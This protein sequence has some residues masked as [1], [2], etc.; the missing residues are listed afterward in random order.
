VELRRGIER[1]IQKVK[2]G[3]YNKTSTSSA[4]LRQEDESGNKYIRVCNRR[5]V[6]DKV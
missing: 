1:G 5:S 3:I 4:W 6:I 2:K